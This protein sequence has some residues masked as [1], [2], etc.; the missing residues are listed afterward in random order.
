[1]SL[2]ALAEVILTLLALVGV[3]W[4]L[5]ATRLLSSADSK[6]INRII[7]Y[8]GLPAL[9]F[10]AVHPA[11]L[12]LDLAGVAAIAWVALLVP[13][14]LAWLSCRALRLPSV[15]AGG[16][17]L[18][19]SLGNTGY[20]GYPIALK[21]LGQDGLVHAIFSDVFGTVAALL[22]V[23]LP[24]AAEM[25]EHEGGRVNPL[26]ELVT[27]PAVIALAVALA[28]RSLPIPE[29][30]SQGL[31]TLANLV[32]PLIMISVGL[33]LEPRTIRPQAVPLSVVAA[34]KLLV[35]PLIAF[36]VA[37]VAGMDDQTTRLVTMQA[38]MP[39]MM[40]SLVIGLRFGL[41]TDFIASAILVT[42]ALSA[43]TIPLLQLLLF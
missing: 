9:I 2:L 4:L 29:P 34:L 22:L 21:L 20:I 6:P 12:S 33:S 5:R 26:K 32:V 10:R 8:V 27:F 18:A 41:D 15:V 39:S 11:E 35:A 28:L 7:V 13:L 43:L 40:L 36:S 42:T 14:A 38:G 25:G 1:M 37:R 16:F 17:L 3:G 19:A 31:E 30:V 24:I 23:G